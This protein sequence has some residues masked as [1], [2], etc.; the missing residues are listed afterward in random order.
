MKDEVSIYGK[1]PFIPAPIKT[2]PYDV[3]KFDDFLNEFIPQKTLAPLIQNISNQYP[4]KNYRDARCLWKGN[5]MERVA[6]VIRDAVFTCNTRLLYDGYQ[7]KHGVPTYMMQYSLFQVEKQ[8]VHASDL[9]PTFWNSGVDY[10]A[11][12]P[13]CFGMN[14]AIANLVANQLKTFAPAYQSYFASHATTGNPN[15][16]AINQ[17]K[18]RK[19]VVASVS[20][21]ALTDVLNAD[22]LD[23][24]FTNIT[25]TINTATNCDF[26]KKIAAATSGQSEDLSF[27]VQDALSSHTDEL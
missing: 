14:K 1:A 20:N 15:V 21:G 5:Q 11:S 10:A 24:L 22:G 7:A 16:N 6:D 4:S 9:L 3:S 13:A 27:V 8:A 18:N 25:D 19:W 17:A 2:S 26:W 12:L 23:P